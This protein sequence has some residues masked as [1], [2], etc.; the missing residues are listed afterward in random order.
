MVARLAREGQ[1]LGKVLAARGLA[2]DATG[3]GD[4][5]I[6]L[7]VAETEMLDN[8]NKK[9][10]PIY[11]VP[12][13]PIPGWW[14][15]DLDRIGGYN[16]FARPNLR[17]VW[18]MD[19]HT[20]ENG[21]P[22]AMKYANPNDTDLGWACFILERYAAPGTFFNET[23]WNQLRYGVDDE[24]KTVDYMGPYPREGSYIKVMEMIDD[25]LAP[26]PSD[27]VFSQQM[28]DEISMRVAKGAQKNSSLGVQEAQRRR[29][30][31]AKKAN[32]DKAQGERR[33]YFQTNQGK[34]DALHTRE[35][36]GL[37]GFNVVEPNASVLKEASKLLLPKG[38]LCQPSNV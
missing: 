33:E 9:I 1:V 32:L 12:A 38:T 4:F 10:W 19:E 30:A 35:Y 14:K 2:S 28:L 26:F 8:T 20:F 24:G 29:R 7:P 36:V 18:G 37:G 15:R 31:A 13:P 11:Y 17:I 25:D 23:L 21:N 22:R 27:T 5:R 16:Q 3:E 34:I 6:I